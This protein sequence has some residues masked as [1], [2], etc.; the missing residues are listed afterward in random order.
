MR[1]CFWN[2]NG[3]GQD[4]LLDGTSEFLAS[5]HVVG[6]CDT[7]NNPAVA[8]VLSTTHHAFLKYDP[9]NTPGSG[10]AILVAKDI[11]PR[12]QFHGFHPHIPLAWLRLGEVSVGSCMH[13][14][15]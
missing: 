4:R 11:L 10:A 12:A 1:L 9:S 13:G 5:H 14:P 3:L 6:I 8:D 7:R 15:P 2:A